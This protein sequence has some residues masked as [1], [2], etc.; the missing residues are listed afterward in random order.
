MS[1][2]FSCVL[3]SGLAKLSRVLLLYHT[4][5]YHLVSQEIAFLK[6]QEAA[7][8][9]NQNLDCEFAF[10]DTS[11]NWGRKLL[12]P[13]LIKVKQTTTMPHR[14]PSQGLFFS[15]LTFIHLILFINFLWY[16]I[17]EQQFLLLTEL[18]MFLHVTSEDAS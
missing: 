1:Q 5:I 16:F 9:F 15:H 3:S 18:K 4:V 11:L 6:H 13:K 2:I 17:F 10:T 8:V 12:Q 7:T 14:G